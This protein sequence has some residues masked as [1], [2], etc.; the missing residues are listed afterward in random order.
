MLKDGDIS[1]KKHSVWP[2]KIRFQNPALAIAKAVI[3]ENSIL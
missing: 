3:F 2:T 1:T